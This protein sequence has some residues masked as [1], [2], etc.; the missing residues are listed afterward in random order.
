MPAMRTA[1]ALTLAIFLVAV[2][3]IGVAAPLPPALSDPTAREA[4]LAA[5]TV[6][7]ESRLVAAHLRGLGL[8]PEAV[9]ARLAQLD[10]VELH[11]LAQALPETAVGGQLQELTWEQK[12]G[13]VLLIIVALALVAAGIYFAAV[14]F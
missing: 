7:L 3:R 9:Q 8:S 14:G 6:A 5:I 12:A 4:D 13:I 11:R 2:P 1:A 10:D